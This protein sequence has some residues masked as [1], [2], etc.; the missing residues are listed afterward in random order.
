MLR[1]LSL[2]FAL[3]WLA[4]TCGDVL[5]APPYEIEVEKAVQYGTGGGEKLLLDLARPKEAAGPRPGIVFIHGGGWAAGNRQSF[6][7]RAQQA[8][9]RGY[10]AVTVSYRFAPRHRFPAQVEDVKCAV[11]WLRAN[12]KRV[13]LDPRRIGAMGSSAGGH[14]SLMLGAMDKDDGLEGT[15]GHAEFS[16]KVQAVVSFVGPTDFTQSYPEAS[17]KI[18]AQFLGGELKEKPEV[19]RR[20]SPITYVNQGDAPMLLLQGTKDP[21]VPFQQAVRMADA[22]TESAVPGR[23]ELLVGLGHGWGGAH[24]KR[25][26]DAAWAFFDEHLKLS[27]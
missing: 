10:V 15:G 1:L 8:A 12:A 6:F 23:V 22:L 11:R 2:T 13:D 17:R 18:V 24:A 4:M 26:A 9:R 19:Y 7:S 27:R 14:L 16:S 5:S 21:L 25:T 20:A 3:L